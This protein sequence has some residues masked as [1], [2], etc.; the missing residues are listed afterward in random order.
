MLR[1]NGQC[2]NEFG[3]GGVETGSA[4]SALS[5]DRDFQGIAKFDRC[6]LASACKYSDYRDLAA[7]VTIYPF[8]SCCQLFRRPNEVDL[9][10][11]RNREFA[12]Q[13]RRLV[14]FHVTSKWV[15]AHSNVSC[16]KNA[17]IPFDTAL[18]GKQEAFN[19]A[20]RMLSAQSASLFCK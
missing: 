15:D 12:L 20:E 5:P 6:S 14:K 2:E 18:A 19:P 3:N 17:E 4:F 9:T 10:W 16:C 13:G 1:Q 7:H 8:G 11:A